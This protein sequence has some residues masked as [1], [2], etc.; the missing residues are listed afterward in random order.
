MKYK[1]IEHEAIHEMS[2]AKLGKLSL[3]ETPEMKL[4]GKKIRPSHKLRD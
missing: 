1:H 2:I 3:G 4:Q